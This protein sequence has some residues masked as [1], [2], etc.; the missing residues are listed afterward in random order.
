MKVIRKFVYCLCVIV[1]QY[2]YPNPSRMPEKS[3]Y[4]SWGMIF[5][6]IVVSLGICCVLNIFP[7]VMTLAEWGLCHSHKY[8]SYNGVCYSIMLHPK[9]DHDNDTDY[10]YDIP[11]I[12]LR[13]IGST[14]H[15][16]FNSLKN[17]SNDLRKFTIY[18]K[19][20]LLVTSF[21]SMTSY[22][23]FLVVFAILYFWPHF[24][25]IFGRTNDNQNN[26]V[27]S[28]PLH[29]FDDD[30]NSKTSTKL[31]SK[32]AHSFYGFLMVNISINVIMMVIFFL[33]Q[34][35]GIIMKQN[36]AYASFNST[37]RKFEKSFT[38]EQS[39]SQLGF[40]IAAVIAYNYSLFCTL[41]SCYIFSK[42]AYG[43][44]NKY[45]NFIDTHLAE[46]N[47]P[48]DQLKERNNPIVQ[49]LQENHDD[50]ILDYYN[51]HIDTLAIQLYY[52][53]EKDKRCTEVA[54]KT[55]N[56]FEMWFF[57]HWI[58]YIVASFLSLSLF[59][60]S[61]IFYINSSQPDPPTV[62]DQRVDFHPFEIAFLG[63]F[64]ASNCLFFFYPCVRAAS[65][66][67]SRDVQVGKLNKL[68]AKYEYVTPELK[69]KF[70][71]FI[72]SQNAGFELHILCARV[73]FGFSVAY[74]SIFIAL[75]S[76][77]IKVATSL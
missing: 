72:K 30:N 40:E 62:G 46:V 4:R 75:F 77:L 76:V 65:I 8:N 5:Y 54:K 19:T 45:K 33:G 18:S 42:L 58:L 12:V 55:I 47:K 50:D 24:K 27:E 15:N 69:D 64:S 48:P 14:S 71:E 21:S 61:L 34:Y 9:K 67:N 51:D 25:I 2:A 74:I 28:I 36:Y 3:K 1:G 16:Q 49:Y 22:L 43:V 44:Q 31:T 10:D 35:L 39:R 17:S 7:F 70:A 23:F 29:P 38:T 37:S 11:K 53:Q 32:Q 41:F 63:F 60:E 66:T 6:F 13:S 68:Y 57:F 20:V 56:M 26:I 59:F 73:P 52:L